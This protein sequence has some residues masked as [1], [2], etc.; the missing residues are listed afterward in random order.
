MPNAYLSFVLSVFPS[1]SSVSNNLSCLL[2]PLTSLAKHLRL[3]T[4]STSCQIP[5]ILVFNIIS[6]KDKTV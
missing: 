3:G 6:K 2:S 5:L 1:S 4:E